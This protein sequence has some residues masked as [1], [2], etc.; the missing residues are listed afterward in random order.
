MRGKWDYNVY[1]SDL[2]VVSTQILIGII[3]PLKD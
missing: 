2:H 1:Q 3:I